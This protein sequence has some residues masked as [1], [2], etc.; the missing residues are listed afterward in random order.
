[1]LTHLELAK[2]AKLNAPESKVVTAGVSV[3]D[4]NNRILKTP[5]GTNAAVLESLRTPDEVWTLPGTTNTM[6]YIKYYNN[7]TWVSLATLEQ[8][9]LE[10]NNWFELTGDAVNQYRKGLL[11]F[12][13]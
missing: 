10:L 7:K 1:L 3:T 2:R 11:I 8:N 12:N 13:K 5:K 6:V 4:Y 9:Q